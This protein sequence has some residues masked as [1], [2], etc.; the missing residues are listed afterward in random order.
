MNRIAAETDMSDNQVQ[1]MQSDPVQPLWFI[2]GACEDDGLLRHHI[3]APVKAALLPQIRWS[4]VTR[5]DAAGDAANAGDAQGIRVSMF[6]RIPGDVL[7]MF[8]LADRNHF[9]QFAQDGQPLVAGFRKILVPGNWLRRQ[10]LADRTLRLTESQVVAAGAPRVDYL[11]GLMA[12][13]PAPAPDAPLTVLVAPLHDNWSDREG[14]PMSMQAAMAPYFDLLGRRVNLIVAEDERNRD[15]KR[16]LTDALLAADIVITDYTSVIYEAWALGKPVIFPRWLTGDRILEKAPHCAEAQIYRDSI[17][18][19]AGS[20]DELIALLARGRGLDLGAGVDAFMADYLDNWPADRSAGDSIARLLE[21]QADAALEAREAAARVALATAVKAADWDGALAPLDSLLRWHPKEAGLQDTL[22]RAM[23]AQGNWRQERTALET[24]LT[25]VPATPGILTRLGDVQARM[26]ANRAAARSYGQAIGLAPKKAT[27]AL[28]YKMAFAWEAPGHDGPPEPRRAAEAYRA[29]CAHDPKSAA[30]RFGEGALHGQNGRWKAAQGAYRAR[31]ASQPLNPELYQRLGMAHDRCYEWPE[32]EAA[33]IRAL[34]LDPGKAAWHYRLGFVLERQ[35]RFD[36]AAAAYL[37]ATS[38]SKT[39]QP[40]WHYRAGYVLEKAGRLDEACAAFLAVRPKAV[41]PAAANPYLDR[42]RAEHIDMVRQLL[43]RTPND[44]GLWISYSKLLEDAGD[45]KGAARAASLAVVRAPAPDDT[46]AKRQAALEARLRALRVT[47]ARLAHDCT[48]PQEW[49]TYSSVLEEHGRLDDAIAAMEQALLRSNDHR[50]DWHHRLGLLLM[51]AGRLA[52]ACTAFRD[53]N[54]LQRPHGTYEDKFASSADLRETATYREFFDVL[55]LMDKAVLYESFGGEGCSDNPLAIFTH[56]RK[57]PRFA[58]WRHFWVVDDMSKAPPELRNCRDVFFVQKETVLYQRLLCTVPYLVNNATFPFYYVRKPGQEY[59]STWHGTPLKTLG[60]DIEATPLQRANTARNLIQASMFIAPNAHT[61]H[62]MLDRYGV[63]NLFTG[64]SLLTGY[65][66]IDMLVNADDAE[67]DRI[68]KRLG[69]DPSK[70]VVLFAPT[71][72]GHWATPELEAQSLADTLERMKSPDYNLVFR[73]HYFA[74]RFIL[75]MNLPV[76]IAPHAIDTCSLLSIV[77]VLVTDYSSIFY[78]FLITRRPVIHFVPDW[79]DY[80]ATRG[81][82]FG[83]DQVP[84]LICETEDQLLVA[85]D[86]CLRD[87]QAQ[88]TQ[89]YLDDLDRYCALE[90]GQ[91]SQRV[92]EAL[93]FAPTPPV[94]PRHP[95]GTRHILVH[96]GDLSDGARLAALRGLLAA[97]RAQGHVNTVVIDRRVVINDEMRTAN[98]R[99]LLDRA[100]VIIRFGKACFSLEEAWVNDKIKMPGY[101]ASAAMQAVFDASLRHE[102][103]RLFGHV[104]FDVVLDFDATR[105]FW[106]NLLSAVPAGQRM[107]RLPGDAVRELRQANPGLERVLHLLPG[108]DCILSETDALTDINRQAL[109]DRGLG[110]DRFATLPACV[111]PA[112]LAARVVQAP[113]DAVGQAFVTRPGLRLLGMP[114]TDP[115]ALRQVLAVLADLLETGQ[116]AHLALLCAPGDDVALTRLLLD[117]RLLADVS[118]LSDAQDAAPLIAA[119][120]VVLIT[121][122]A[123]FAAHLARE[124]HQIGTP[125]AWLEGAAMTPDRIVDLAATRATAPEAADITAQAALAALIRPGAA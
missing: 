18:H 70:P 60:Y 120:A 41:P 81:M 4:D 3:L 72:R 82:Y 75:D 30:A 62:V 27:A 125:V 79:D 69:L 109:A 14:R 51:R 108:F 59:L 23:N 66:R 64:R 5:A 16:P 53:Q 71:Y 37:H 34:A 107:I 56:V 39:H 121:P 35:D 49:M 57:D 124:A 84:G 77:D 47:E 74:E 13:R 78:D 93:F 97:T 76:T 61:E 8:D 67:K 19:H 112:D 29:A 12:A 118:L 48:R 33:Y 54:I 7:L 90:D 105:P 9:R 46:Y 52:A 31:L 11:R 98:A 116:A 87:P 117:A 44:T 111:A 2:D 15:A 115:A 114:G 55:P 113:K 28:F 65:P 95:E 94:Q 42:F 119:A 63:R 40:D 85:L 10:I 101:Q 91:A 58:G 45:L 102:V 83:K 89:Q 103:R 32:A 22:A 73:G 6:P 24:L 43:D 25:M 99:A 1:P 86:A 80:V 100:D 122:G 26:G 123:E 88:I 50:P 38:L 68:R 17:G 96:G 36:D 92:I 21:R 110:A 104:W 106:G 20:L